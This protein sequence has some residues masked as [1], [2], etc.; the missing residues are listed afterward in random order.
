MD[1]DYFII[2][3]IDG[4][5][6][7]WSIPGC[8]VVDWTEVREIVTAVCYRPDGKVW[9]S[10]ELLACC[11]DNIA[12]AIRNSFI[13]PIFFFQ[14]GIIGSMSGI[15]YFYD[16]SGM[17]LLS[18]MK[19]HFRFYYGF[20][21]DYFSCIVIIEVLTPVSNLPIHRFKPFI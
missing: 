12:S 13:L 5:V 17:C 8:Q 19:V 7:I 20:H 4:K 1:D 16:A 10:I 3:S 21:C 14:G 9:Q 18:L 2:G 11:D 6:R 15:C